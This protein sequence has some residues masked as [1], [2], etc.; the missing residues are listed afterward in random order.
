MLVVISSS[1]NHV[2]F[3][4][5]KGTAYCEVSQYTNSMKLQPNRVPSLPVFDEREITILCLLQLVRTSAKGWCEV[6]GG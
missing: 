3:S 6:G 2:L 1:F 5:C 4:G